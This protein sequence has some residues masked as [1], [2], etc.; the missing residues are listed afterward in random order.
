MDKVTSFL[1]DSLEEVQH[2]V[3]WP[4][5]GDL[6]ASSTLVLIASLIFALLVGGIDFLFENALNLFYQ[7]F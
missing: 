1:K 7:S 4:K 5:F 3:T 6:Q 2:N